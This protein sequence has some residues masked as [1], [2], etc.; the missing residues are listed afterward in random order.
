MTTF[1]LVKRALLRITSF[2]T[3]VHCDIVVRHKKYECCI[4]YMKTE[5]LKKPALFRDDLTHFLGVIRRALIRFL[6]CEIMKREIINLLNTF[7][8]S[9]LSLMV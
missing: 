8:I 9:P 5:E 1:Y 7:I 6:K 4:S 2:D 3:D